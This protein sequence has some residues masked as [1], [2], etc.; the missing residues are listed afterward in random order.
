MDLKAMKKKDHSKW[1][2]AYIQKRI[3][4][5]LCRQCG[6]EPVINERYCKKC[7]P[8]LAAYAREWAR[9]NHPLKQI[10]LK[11][12][13]IITGGKIPQCSQCG[14]DILD[15]LEINHLNGKG[16]EEYKNSSYH[17]YRSIILG[18]RSTEDLDIRCKV[19]NAVHF[20]ERKTEGKWRI[21]YVRSS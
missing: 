13:Q 11:A 12:V 16:Y 9:K 1:K 15:I 4:A 2:H 6:K 5:G 17:F 8:K 10:R 19:C 7:K 18:L 3:D 14:C 21:R 20:C